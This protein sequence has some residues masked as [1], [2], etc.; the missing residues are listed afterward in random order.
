M[1]YDSKLVFLEFTKPSKVPWI[2]NNRWENALHYTTSISFITTL[3]FR[4][5]NHCKDRLA[6]IDLHVYDFIWWD[7][8]HIDILNGIFSKVYWASLL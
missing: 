6:N 4:D 3:M 8:I 5:G 1:E 7:V 2:L